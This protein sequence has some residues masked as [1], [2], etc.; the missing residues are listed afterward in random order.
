ML[1][2]CS[3]NASLESK[4]AALDSWYRHQLSEVI[5]P[6]LEEWAKKFELEGITWRMRRMKTKWATV[7]VTKR[8]I[9]INPELANRAMTVWSR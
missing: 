6:L 2:R 4:R 5:T 1:L 8:I 7:D 9:T 3:S